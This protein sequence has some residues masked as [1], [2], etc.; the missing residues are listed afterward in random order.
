MTSRGVVVCLPAEAAAGR[1]SRCPKGT[2]HPTLVKRSDRAKGST[3]AGR[4]PAVP[5]KR[6]CG[7]ALSVAAPDPVAAAGPYTGDTNG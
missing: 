6:G 5:A 2:Y 1:R 4:R 7:M 3:K